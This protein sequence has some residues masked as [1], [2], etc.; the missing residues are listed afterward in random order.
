M[1]FYFPVTWLSLSAEP[2][3]P[4][5]QHPV[6]RSAVAPVVAATNTPVV[7]GAREPP[8]PARLRSSW[9]RKIVTEAQLPFIEAERVPITAPFPSRWEM[10][11]PKTGRPE[12]K[13]SPGRSSQTVLSVRPEGEKPQPK[14]LSTPE[15]TGGMIG[16]GALIGL[17]GA[18]LLL[19]VSLYFVMEASWAISR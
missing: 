8:A 18:V 16:T 14:F 12:S 10:V 15:P 13:P 3:F 7:A 5:I 4:G 17:G 6:A 2:G 9:A 11:I 19:V 1:K